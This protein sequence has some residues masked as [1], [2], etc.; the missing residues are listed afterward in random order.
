MSLNPFRVKQWSIGI[1]EGSSID[2]LIE[3]PKNPVLTKDDVTDCIAGFLADPFLIADE[4]KYYLFFEVLNIGSGK[5]EIAYA[6]SNDKIHWEYGSIVLN[7]KFHLSYPYIFMWNNSIYLVPESYQDKSVRLYKAKNFPTE[8][9]YVTNLLEGDTYT[10]NSILYYK[11]KFWMFTYVL[12]IKKK[13]DESRLEIWSA[14]NLEGKWI[15]HPQNPISYGFQ[16]PSRSGGRITNEDTIKR[17]AQNT[18]NYYGQELYMSIITKLNEQD[19]E[20]EIESQPF[21]ISKGATWNELGTHTFDI[22][23]ISE[24][25]YLACTDGLGYTTLRSPTVILLKIRNKLKNWIGKIKG[26]IWGKK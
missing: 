15:P 10:D 12:N 7:E 5:G 4:N 16:I 21:C 14:D 22:I 6:V 23:K 1:H 3:H 19:F 24:Y 11:E 17:F 2:T 25:N 13:K 18:A 8:W 9:E 26:S 20:Q